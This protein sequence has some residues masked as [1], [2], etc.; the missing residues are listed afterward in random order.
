MLADEPDYEEETPEE[1]ISALDEGEPVEIEESVE[2]ETRIIRINPQ[3]GSTA[4]NIFAVIA[5]IVSGIGLI[6]LIKKKKP[7]KA[8]IKK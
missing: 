3:T 8:E 5:L 6:I 1:L 7:K 4:L 2:I